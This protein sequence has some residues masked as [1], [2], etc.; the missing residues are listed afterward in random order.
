MFTWFVKVNVLGS[1]LNNFP[2][3]FFSPLIWN[4]FLKNIAPSSRPIFGLKSVVSLKNTN[5]KKKTCT[6]RE[7]A[8]KSTMNDDVFPIIHG[9][10]PMSC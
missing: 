7:N 10:F 6:P 3:V 2:W 5:A 8:G 4:I 1:L 9:D